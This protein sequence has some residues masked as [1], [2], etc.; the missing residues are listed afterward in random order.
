MIFRHLFR[1]SNKIN[2]KNGKNK[3]VPSKKTWIVDPTNGFEI[4]EGPSLNV[5]RA[6]HCCGKM[7]V[8]GKVILVVVGGKGE[9]GCDHGELDSVELLDPSSMEEGWKF[10]KMLE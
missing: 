8:D 5:A 10:G 2:S 9:L 4:K 6:S 3:K 1:G 7:V